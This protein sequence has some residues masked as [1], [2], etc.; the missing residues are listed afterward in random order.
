M[1]AEVKTAWEI[2]VYIHNGTQWK[3]LT[4]KRRI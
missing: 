2:F 3:Q 4:L 1:C